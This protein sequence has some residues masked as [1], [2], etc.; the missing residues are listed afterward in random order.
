MAVPGQQFLSNYFLQPEG[1]LAALALIPLIIFYLVKKKPDEEV[2]P[3][4]MFF[5]KDRKSGKARTALRTFLRNLLLLFHILLILGMAAAIADP[6]LNA[7]ANS[8][9]AVIVFDSSASMEDDLEAAK[10]FA[11]SNLGPKN[12]LIKVAESADIPLEKAP[13]S[14]TSSEID[15]ISSGDTE[16]DIA[17]ALEIASRYAGPIIVASDLDQTVNS[18]DASE[19]VEQL[20]DSGR[21]V[22]VFEA[23]D[24]NSWGITGIEDNGKNVSI[25]VK[26]FENSTR[27]LPVESDNITKEVRIEPGAVGT[28]NFELKQGKNRFSLPGD[29]LEADNKAFF[30]YPSQENYQV[31]L[32][33]DEENPYMRKTFDLI[34]F[35]DF[36][37]LQPPIE[38]ELNSDVYIL[39]DSN[40]ILSETVSEIESQTKNGKAMISYAETGLKLGIESLPI[41]KTGES[42]DIAVEIR[43]PRRI[44][45]GETSVIKVNRTRGESLTASS[46]ALVR[47]SL[48]EGEILVYNIDDDDFNKDFLYPVFWKQITRELVDRPSTSQLNLETGEQLEV[49]GE[50][51]DLNEAGFYNSSG[52][53]YAANL[54]SEDESSEETVRTT[55]KSNID[56]GTEQRNIQNLVA[57]L[58]AL[59]VVLEMAYLYRIGEL[60]W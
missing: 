49:N 4:I 17:N 13:S 50:L 7:P 36:E 23:S 41:E 24:S 1:F 31:T 59:L 56:E 53:T 47:A 58:L 28:V 51:Q 15:Q 37:R 46:N 33:S 35:T 29:D 26:N 20:R 3:S 34:K 9:R 11:K 22:K 6:F 60:E 54:E 12:T 8:D 21:T 18:Q 27:E 19:V 25:D 32:I 16:T 38:Q 30:F 44:D 2:M 55:T 42:R 52:K 40:N 39:G 45:I 5:M 57:T 43:R 48:G 14:S 10:S